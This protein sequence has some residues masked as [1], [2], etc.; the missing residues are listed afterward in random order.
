MNQDEPC[1]TSSRSGKVNPEDAS[2]LS[3]P[4]YDSAEQPR[5][6]ISIHRMPDSAD[7][8]LSPHNAPGHDARCLVHEARFMMLTILMDKDRTHQL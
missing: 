8:Y 3:F 5:W 1:V 6:E 2:C 7:I 4:S